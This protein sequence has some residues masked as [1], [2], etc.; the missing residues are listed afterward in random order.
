MSDESQVR[1]TADTNVFYYLGN[2]SATKTNFVFEGEQL[3]ATPVNALELVSGI[4][5][6][7][8]KARKAAAA[9]IVENGVMLADPESHLVSIFKRSTAA[10]EDF[11]LEGM[12]AL[13]QASSEDELGSGVSDFKE[14]VTRSVKTEFAKAFRASH[15][16][17]FVKDVAKACDQ[18]VPGYADAVA[19]QTQA[20]I[21]EKANRKA[22]REFFLSPLF[23][24]TV[25]FGGLA[26]RYKL[27]ANTTIDI[28]KDETFDALRDLAPYCAVYGAYLKGLATERRKPDVND[29][30]DLELFL[31]LQ[32]DTYIVTAEKRWRALAAEVG[33]ESR[34]RNTSG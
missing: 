16:E 29:W 20:P 21:V 6:K 10:P 24:A 27:I 11:W 14:K 19:N 22:I 15:Y 31:Y 9:A 2:G 26:H 4:T 1:V 7:S 23:V 33:L 13:A 32:P 28:Q 34:V 17:D 5:L 8:W 25:F 3:Y 30:G 12:K 18:L